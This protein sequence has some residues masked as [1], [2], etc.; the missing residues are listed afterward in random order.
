M[1]DISNCQGEKTLL[2]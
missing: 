1:G 2:I